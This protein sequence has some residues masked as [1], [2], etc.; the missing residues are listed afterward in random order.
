MGV[1]RLP[2]HRA[3]HINNARPKMTRRP[4]RGGRSN[5]EARFQTT[6]NRMTAA[7]INANHEWLWH[8]LDA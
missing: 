6:F 4:R 3:E 8:W 7:A 2:L 5:G 1:I